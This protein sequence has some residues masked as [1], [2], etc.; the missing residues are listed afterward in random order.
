MGTPF[1]EGIPALPFH[2]VSDFQAPP[3]AVVTRSVPPTAVTNGS[4]DGQTTP[5]AVEEPW[6]PV[7]TRTVWPCTAISLKIGSRLFSLSDHPQEQ[8]TCLEVLSEAILLKME[9]SFDPT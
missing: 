3:G 6:S 5:A 2:P 4:S 8:L 1:L 7:A 9:T